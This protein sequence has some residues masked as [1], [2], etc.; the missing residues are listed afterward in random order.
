[1]QGYAVQIGI[2]ALRRSKPYNM[3]S[4]YWQLNDV[5]PV[6]S[7]ASVDFYGQWKMAQYRA[8]DLYRDL[9][10]SIQAD[11]GTTNAS[12]TTTAAN[13]FI[14]SIVNDYLDVVTGTLLV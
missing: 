10:I 1:M 2:E 3:G 14:V 7:W 6:F 13:N 8:R 5:W 11:W 4:L 12:N 9:M